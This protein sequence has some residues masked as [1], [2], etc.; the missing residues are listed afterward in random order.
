MMLR[1]AIPVLL[2][3]LLAGPALAEETS[4]DRGKTLVVTNCSK[5]H[6]TGLTGKSPLPAAPPFREV[7]L[8]YTP[9][10]LVDGFMEGLAVRH[11]AM[12]EWQMS[13]DQAQAIAAYVLSLKPSPDAKAADSPTGVG[14]ALL[15]EHCA[16]CH[17][18]ALEGDS[19]LAKAPPFRDVVKRYDPS[20]LQEALAEG[21]VTG[22]NEMPEFEFSPDEIAGIIAYLDSLKPE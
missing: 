13:L 17:A 12:P 18:I 2:A 6:A 5:C 14:F 7:A 11:E 15:Q 19:P 9:E 10:E 8:N 21:I 4:W 1:P 22:H 16:R 20:Q 3:L